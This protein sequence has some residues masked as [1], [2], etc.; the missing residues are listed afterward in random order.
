[1]VVV[2]DLPSSLA[3]WPTNSLL[4]KVYTQCFRNTFHFCDIADFVQ[5]TPSATA[6]ATATVPSSK[7][8][9]SG[10]PGSA[11]IRLWG[12]T[13]KKH[14]S[15]IQLWHQMHIFHHGFLQSW[16]WK[17]HYKKDGFQ[18]KFRS[19][20]FTAIR[21]A[22]NPL[23]CHK[24]SRL[25]LVERYDLK[26]KWTVKGLYL[27]VSKQAFAKRT[28]PKESLYGHHPIVFY[29]EVMF[30]RERTGCSVESKVFLLRPLLSPMPNLSHLSDALMGHI[31]INKK[32]YMSCHELIRSAVFLL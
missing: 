23:C 5:V 26:I 6:S 20:F 9:S 11:D 15:K 19:I 8:G 12:P 1:M 3:H 14:R 27:F 10:W 4:V 18:L 24:V 17:H 28:M 16:V 25:F 21:I 32:T 13:C 30:V 7:W 22:A 2:C 31:W 29:L